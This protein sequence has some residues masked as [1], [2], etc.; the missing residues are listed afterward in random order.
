MSCSVPVSVAAKLLQRQFV[1]DEALAWKF[2][3]VR[4]RDQLA[5]RELEAQAS[6]C[7]RAFECWS[8]QACSG[9]AND[10]VCLQTHLLPVS[11]C[12]M[13]SVQPRAVP[14]PTC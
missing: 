8:C 5:K 9:A 6:C 1:R 2:E 13:L 14:K 3:L 7:C 4:R 10:A 11:T 12:S